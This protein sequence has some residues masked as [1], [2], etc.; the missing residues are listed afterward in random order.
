MARMKEPE[1]GTMTI[2]S[3]QVFHILVCWYLK[4]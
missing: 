1:E 4:R 2:R 3:T